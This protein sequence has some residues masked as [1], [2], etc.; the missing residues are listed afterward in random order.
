MEKLRAIHKTGFRLLKMIHREDSLIIP[1][2]LLE[3]V[4]ALVQIYAGLFVTAD[5]VDALLSGEYKAGA[6]Q[7]LL[8]LGLNLVLGLTQQLLRRQFKSRRTKIWLIFYVWLR[9]KAFSMDY[10]TLENPEA[11]EKLLFSERTSDMYGGLGTLVG[12]YTDILQAVSNIFL[13]VFMVVC[14]CVSGPEENLGLL[15][16]LAGPVPSFLLFAGALAGMVFGAWRVFGKYAGRQM[17]IFQAHTGEEHKLMYLRQQVFGNAKVG[18]IIRIYG[19][20]EMILNN[21]LKFNHKA[22]TYFA[23][24]SDVGRE[25]NNA[26]RLVSSAFAICAYLLVAL[27]TVTGAVSVGAFTRYVGAL[28][29]FGGA[30]FS[31]IAKHGEL[32]KICTY[33][34]EFLAFLDT[35]NIHAKG[36][37]PVEKRDDGEYELAF[38]NVSFRYPGSDTP[39][40]KN[41]NCRI[42]I[43]GKLAVVGRNGAGKTTFIK[44]LCRLYEPTEGRITLNGVDIRK[45]DEEEYRGLFGVVFQDFKLFSFSVGEN[46][47]AGYERQE[48]RIWN[49]LRQ[50]EAE[51][52]VRGMEKQL[53]TC[54]YKDLEDGVEI[55]GGEAQKLALARALYKNAPVVILDEPTAA[56]DP[57]AEAQIY[58]RFNEMMEGRTGIY[59]SHRMSSCRFCDEIIVFD[60]GEI[61][62]RGSH[63]ALCCAGGKYAQMWN[64][65]AK[66]Y[67]EE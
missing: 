10:E 50:A 66:Y 32:Q 20:E 26:N 17:A 16:A 4:L 25:E 1:S 60:K 13:S 59:I 11:A 63:E 35:E 61:V 33:M 19:M 44:L 2:H 57:M 15:G 5:M 65:Q 6:G 43:R 56:L 8:L 28:N 3:A 42:N 51:D 9:E 18:K 24:S 14:L 37:V 46:I 53:D 23:L 29:Q 38:E 64:A 52:L 7:A 67:N 36:T 22:R 58:A 47:A 49:S 41:V 48:E 12:Y 45:Y 62:E 31:V 21:F 34:D 30:C 54:L 39:V 40:L 55:S 27:K